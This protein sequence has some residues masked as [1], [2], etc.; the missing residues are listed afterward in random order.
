MLDVFLNYLSRST[1]ITIFVLTWLSIYFVITLT[2]LIS[3]YLI[4]NSWINNEKKAL[5]ILLLGGRI[6]N[7]PSVL[8]KYVIGAISQEKINV[9]LSIS[10]KNSTIGLTWLS[11]VAS[12]SPFIGLFG[13]VISILDTFAKMGGGNAG[14]SVIAPAISEALVATGAGIFVAI[15][16]YTFHLLIKRKSYEVMSI[17]KR[18]S[19]L[20]LLNSKS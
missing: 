6:S 20:I 12:T 8:K 3:R 14:I 2:I 13:T 9:C 11:I 18:S 19:D 16:A 1:F 4:I 15:P 7:F 17:I 10:E 5:D